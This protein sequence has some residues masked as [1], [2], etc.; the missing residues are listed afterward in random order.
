METGS[1]DSPRKSRRLEEPTK[2]PFDIEHRTFALMG[3]SH[4]L[5]QNFLTMPLFLTSAMVIFLPLYVGS[6]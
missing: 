5:F 3:F 1:G 2:K 4:V 6:M